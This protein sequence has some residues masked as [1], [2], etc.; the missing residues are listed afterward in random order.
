[1]FHPVTVSHAHERFID[2]DDILLG[3]SVSNV[4][5]L[6]TV[7]NFISLESQYSFN[8][9]LCPSLSLSLSDKFS[10]C[11]LSFFYTYPIQQVFWILYRR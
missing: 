6:I 11:F 10:I 4:S 7:N 5:F 1:M 3:V 2:H 9:R 8:A